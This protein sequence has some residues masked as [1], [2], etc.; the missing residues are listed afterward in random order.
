MNVMTLSMK[1]GMERKMDT[2]KTYIN[3][4]MLSLENAD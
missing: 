1:H 3:I 4:A 2:Q